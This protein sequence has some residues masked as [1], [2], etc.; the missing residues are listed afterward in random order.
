MELTVSKNEAN[1]NAVALEKLM[2]LFFSQDFMLWGFWDGAMNKSLVKL[3][4][5]KDKILCYK[6]NDKIF[7]PPNRTCKLRFYPHET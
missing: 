7:P 1:K 6:Y 2:T 4:N 3:F 5:L